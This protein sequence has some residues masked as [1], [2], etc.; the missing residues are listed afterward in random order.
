MAPPSY[1]SGSF[2]SAP[3]YQH[4]IAS[5]P[6]AGYD[7]SAYTF[8]MHAPPSSSSAGQSLYPTVDD[9]MGLSLQSYR[10]PAAPAVSMD[11]I[12]FWVLIL[13]RRMCYKNF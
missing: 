4:A 5:A 11:S 6:A 2:A 12:P 10:S 1:G 7:A 3:L 9:Y 8:S 13:G